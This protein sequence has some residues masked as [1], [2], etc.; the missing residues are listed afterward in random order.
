MADEVIV[1]DTD[2]P[3]QVHAMHGGVDLAHWKVLAR[4]MGLAG[5]WE[6]VELSTLPPGAECGVHH[7]SR[8]E[9]LYFVVSGTG[10]LLL[11]GTVHQV[12]PGRLVVNPV[13]TRHRLNNPGSE[14]LSW[15]VIEIVAPPTAR[16][17]TGGRARPGRSIMA[18]ATVIDLEREGSVDLTTLLAG[19]L[20]LARLVTLDPGDTAELAATDSEHTVFVLEGAGHA[21]AGGS[22]VDLRAGTAI[23]LPL[24][25]RATVVADE[26]QLRWFH[27]E[28]AVP[29]H[30][31][32]AS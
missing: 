19:P 11:N 31:E 25:S 14:S 16:V 30:A 32:V 29:E 12:G 10:E 4:R 28:L 22:R 13:G 1:A 5:D 24:G 15:L 27:A 8:T 23:T 18:P 20:R 7:H 9:E 2:A 17:L 26:G 21:W 6:A 3:S